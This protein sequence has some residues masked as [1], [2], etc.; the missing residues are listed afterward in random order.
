ML[1]RLVRFI[2]KIGI[3]ILQAAHILVKETVNGKIK[4]TDF[5]IP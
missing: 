4:Y 3:T 1:V 2:V 5:Q